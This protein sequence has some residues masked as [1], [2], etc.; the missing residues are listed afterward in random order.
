M[1][2]DV[3]GMTNRQYGLNFRDCL[4]FSIFTL[5]SSNFFL[6]SI[7]STQANDKHTD[8]RLS[9]VHRTTRHP[10]PENNVPFLFFSCIWNA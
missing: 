5:S 8:P 1:D 4:S 2:M 7:I 9:C 10:Q 6:R 3:L